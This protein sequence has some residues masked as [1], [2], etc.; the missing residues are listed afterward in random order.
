[1]RRGTRGGALLALPLR[2]AYSI[3][4]RVSR[5]VLLLLVLSLSAH[6]ADMGLEASGHASIE[7]HTQTAAP[8]GGTDTVAGAACHIAAHVPCLPGR[9]TAPQSPRG[10]VLEARYSARFVTVF[11]PNPTPPPIA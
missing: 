7:S 3:M 1:M 11:L 4:K 10:T 6:A 5:A 2:L 9:W 8:G